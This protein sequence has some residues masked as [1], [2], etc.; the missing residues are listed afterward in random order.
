MLYVAQGERSALFHVERGVCQ[1]C[2]MDAHGAQYA[3]SACLWSHSD[4]SPGLFEL[5]KRLPPNERWDTILREHPQFASIRYAVMGCGELL[6]IYA[7]IERSL[8]MQHEDSIVL[9]DIRG[10]PPVHQE[11]T[12]WAELI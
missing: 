1:N 4:S 6:F 2:S 11:A 3:I 9:I 7:L 8:V 5:V 12:A 10:Q